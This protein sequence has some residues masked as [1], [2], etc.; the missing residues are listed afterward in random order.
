MPYTIIL[1]TFLNSLSVLLL[2]TLLSKLRFN[3]RDTITIAIVIGSTI[4]CN[5]VFL[6]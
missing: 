2:I 3:M 5:V 6:K 4:T 1:L